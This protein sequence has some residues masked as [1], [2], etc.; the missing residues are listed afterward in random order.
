MTSETIS[1]RMTRDYYGA[2]IGKLETL[3]LDAGGVLVVPNW[4]R[5][6]DALRRHGIEVDAPAIAA[7]EPGVKFAIDTFVGVSSSSDAKRWGDYLEGVLTGAGVP[8]AGGTLEAL[9]ELRAYH[10]AHNLWETVPEDVMP[11][12]DRI[13]R[14]GLKVAVASNA[15]GTVQR[16]FDRLGLAAYFDAICDSHFEGVEK[17]DPR[18][19]ELVLER[20]GGRPETTLHVG[21]LYHVDVAGARSAGLAAILVDRHDQYAG[22]D[23][24]RVGTLLELAERIA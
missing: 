5:V 2:V 14:L 22:F 7:A 10:A 24:D 12:L 9:K 17:P 18:F 15:N 11:A 4:E 20:C 1:Q 16:A 13:R 8:L 23:V 21:D 3:L 6:A 19:F